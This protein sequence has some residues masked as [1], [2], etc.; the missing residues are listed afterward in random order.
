VGALLYLNFFIEPYQLERITTF[1]NPEEDPMGAGYQILQ[2][3]IA[4][5]SG[6]P[7]GK[8]FMQGTQ[9]SLDFLPEKQTDFI[10]TMLGEEFGFVG[11]I[12]VSGALCAAAGQLRADRLVLQIHLPA[13]DGDGRRDDLLALCFHQC[14]HGDGAV[15]RGRGA[16]C[17]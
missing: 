10:F 1:L 13:P 3:Q 12:V 17:R 14:R 7:T 9:A 11:G 6:G 16:R 8:G 2:S 15:A 4:L 5:G